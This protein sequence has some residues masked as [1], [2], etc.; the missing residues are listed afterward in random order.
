MEVLRRRRRTIEK[1][2]SKNWS[3]TS[4]RKSK[5]RRAKW[6]RSRGSRATFVMVLVQEVLQRRRRM[7]ARRMMMSRGQGV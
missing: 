5:H 6:A 3:S 2:G 4:G 1:E 7:T